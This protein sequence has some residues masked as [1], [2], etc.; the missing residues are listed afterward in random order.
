[1]IVCPGED[2]GLLQYVVHVT[3][4]PSPQPSGVQ[5]PVR[6]LQLSVT[7]VPAEQVPL[8]DGVDTKYGK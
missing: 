5:D 7:D 3:V 1:M 6:A 2:A 8:H 4:H